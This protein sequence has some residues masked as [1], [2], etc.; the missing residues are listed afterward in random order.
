MVRVDIN[1]QHTLTPLGECAGGHCHV[2]EQAE[3]HRSCRQRVMARRT[4]CTERGITLAPLESFDC[5]QT[6]AGGEH[7]HVER[8]R[9][10]PGVGIDAAAALLAELLDAVDI[11][12]IVHP[13]DLGAGGRPRC[14]SDDRAVEVGAAHSVEHGIESRGTFGVAPAGH[15][16]EIALMRREQ[17]RH[18]RRG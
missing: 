14:K 15:V 4:H 8:R 10:G 6:G 11:V 12:R 16:I 5:I 9:T 2:V 7:R 18:S 17:D 13:L 1:E 3:A